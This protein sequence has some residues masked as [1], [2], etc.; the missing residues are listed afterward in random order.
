MPDPF[1]AIYAELRALAARYL[2]DE[3][4]EHTLQ[5]TALVHEAW[6]RLGA[7]RDEAPLDRG[8]FFGLAARAMRRVLVD[9]A[10]AKGTAKRGAGAARVPLDE[11]AAQLTATEVDLLGLDGALEKLAA[12]EPELARVVD[13]RFFAGLELTEI[14]ILVGRSERQVR[15]DWTLARCWLERELAEV[16]EP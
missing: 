5:P 7:P 11:V 15:Y 16:R 12:Q 9:H 8:I 4:L 1:L 14:G 2:A 6:L 13:L 10:R 3:R